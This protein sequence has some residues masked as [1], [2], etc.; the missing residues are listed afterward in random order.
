MLHSCD[1]ILRIDA[2]ILFHTTGK[3]APFDPCI[4]ITLQCKF[5]QPSAILN[6][7]TSPSLPF[8][9]VGLISTEQASFL[10]SRP[11]FYGA[12]LIFTEQASFLRSRPHFYETQP[13]C[14][15]CSA[16]NKRESTRFD[17]VKGCPLWAT[18]VN[19]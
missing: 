19:R 8:Y 3:I 16:T 15:C 12:G 6:H 18:V 17:S 9:G 7:A 10:R 14:I 1:K 5:I 11:H 13:C 4:K 2:H